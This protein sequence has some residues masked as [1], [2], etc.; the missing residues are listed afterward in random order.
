MK[1]LYIGDVMAEPG[2]KIVE[3]VLPALKK[4]Q[5]ISLVLAQ[6]ENLSDGKGIRL[7]DFRRLRAAGVDFCTGGNHTLY[8]EDI[9]AA[10]SDPAQPIIRPA[11]YPHETPGAG[12]KYVDTPGGKVL[13]VS[14][15]GQIV[16][17]DADK[18]TDNPLQVID[19]ILAAEKAVPKA[20]VVVNF[21]GDFSSQKRIIGY[22][23]DGR[24]TAVI[25]DHW[26]V[27]TADADVLP[28]GTA[29]VTDVGMCGA[30]DS[31]LGVAFDSVVARWRD[32]V[33][34]R[35]VL[36][37]GGRMQFNALLVEFDPKT[38]KA[39]HAERIQHTFPA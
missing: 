34:T 33:V 13:V 31:S 24:V 35:N 23:L 15:L 37:T 25:G 28:K 3:K 9:Y 4:E 38:G 5:G 21:H 26:H 1:L 18:P 12:Y 19:Q 2:I 7:E 32:G 20:G 16:G 30:L 22:Y 10:L 11:N 14:L 8:R 39:T 27:P 6:A 17:K 36:E 29:H